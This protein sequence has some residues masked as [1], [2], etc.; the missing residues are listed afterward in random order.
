MNA[1]HTVYIG[2]GSNLGDRQANITEA[3]QHLRAQVRIR[4]VASLYVT[5][6]AGYLDQPRFLNTAV[7]GETD[8][9]PRDLL[10]FLKGIERRLGRQPSFRN[11]PRPIDMDILAYGDEIVD[12]PGLR[13]PHQR[14]SE[15]AFVLVPLAEIAPVLRLPD[16][17]QTVAELLSRVDQSGVRLARRGLGLRLARDVQGEPPEVAVRLSRVGV[18]DVRKTIRLLQGGKTHSLPAELSLFADIGAE[19]KGL[20]MSR[21]SHALDDVID[22]SVGEHVPDVESLAAR[23]AERV[24]Q[25]HKARRSEVRVRAHFPLRRYA[26]VSGLPTQ[27]M[28]TLLG[29]A[30]WR[31]DGGRRMVGIEAEG[32]TACPCAQDMILQHSRE[33]LQAAGFGGEE[34]ERILRAVPTAAHNQRSRAT[35]MVGTDASIRAQDLVEIAESS[36]SSENYGLLKRP[37]EFFVVHKAHRRPRFVEDVAREM[38]EAAVNTYADLPGDDF[39]VARVVSYESIHKHNAYAEGEG[40]LDELRSQILQG[41]PATTGTTL[42]QWLG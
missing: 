28:Y 4:T 20:H 11:A 13:I 2:V 12:A 18:T 6:P 1:S 38:L 9:S 8:L 19:Q 3:L 21:F 14:L 10:G 31:P 42:E 35:V 30:V 34:I 32:M 17:Q 36:M 24:I 29:L 40:T 27:E 5:E 16:A 23:I 22:E 7:E 41:Q 37:D 26:P 25:R 33:Q 39:L 15:R